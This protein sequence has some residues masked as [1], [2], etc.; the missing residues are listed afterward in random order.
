MMG[1]TRHSVYVDVIVSLNL[2]DRHSS[3]IVVISVQERSYD[4]VAQGIFGF[5]FQCAQ[6]V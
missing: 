2:F 4:D 6:Q 5:E 1:L 3:G